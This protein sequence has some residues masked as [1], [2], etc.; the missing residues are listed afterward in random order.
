MMKLNSLKQL[1]KGLSIII[2]LI[3]VLGLLLQPTPAVAQ[4]NQMFSANIQTMSCPLS[5]NTLSGVTPPARIRDIFPDPTFARAVGY[6]LRNTVGVTS[7]NDVVSQDDL[8]TITWLG[9]CQILADEQPREI[10]SLEGI[11][12]LKNLKVLEMPNQEI[13]DISILAGLSQLF[14]VDLSYNPIADASPLANTGPI[15]Y[16][17]LSGTHINSLNFLASI[18]YDYLTFL[19]VANTQISDIDILEPFLERELIFLDLS[20]TQVSDISVLSG[21]NNLI[22]LN[23]FQTQVYDISALDFDELTQLEHIGLSN[24]SYAELEALLTTTTRYFELQTLR[25]SNVDI[26]YLILLVDQIIYLHN[27]QLYQA[28]IQDLSFLNEFYSLKTLNL[29]HNQINDQILS[30]LTNMSWKY[31]EY[32]DLSYNN[33]TNANHLKNLW[34]DFGWIDSSI[35]ISNNKISDISFLFGWDGYFYFG[36]FDY[37]NVSHNQISDLSPFLHIESFR[38]HT[39]NFSH[40]QIS[41][42]APIIEAF[43]EGGISISRLILSHNLIEN[44]EAMADFD[45]EWRAFFLNTLDL[46]HNRISDLSPLAKM[47]ENLD[48]FVTPRVNLSHNRIYDISP[49][50]FLASNVGHFVLLDL[51]VTN[52]SITRDEILLSFAGESTFDIEIENPLRTIEGDY[53]SAFNISHGGMLSTSLEYLM[54]TDL[55]TDVTELSLMFTHHESI[56]NIPVCPWVA[57]IRFSGTIIQPLTGPENV[58][59]IF[60]LQD[61]NIDGVTTN[62]IVSDVI[63]GTSLGGNM[64]ADPEK[65]GF[66]FIGWN[67]KPD[68]TGTVFDSTTV[69]IGDITIYAQ[70]QE[71]SQ[72]KRYTVTF[73]LRGGNIGGNTA[74]YQVTDVVYGET[75]VN[76]MPGNPTRTGFTFAGWFD[77][78]NATGGN[79]FTIATAVYED[80]TVFARWQTAGGGGTGGGSGG[81]DNGIGNGGENGVNG[82][83]IPPEVPG[84][85]F[86]VPF[87]SDHIAYLVGFQDGTIRPNSTITRAEVATIFFRLITDEY[88]TQIWSQSNPFRDVTLNNWFNN[89]VSTL[90]NA[91][92]IE[93]FPD[94]TFRGNQAITRAEFATMIARFVEEVDY[95]GTDRFNDIN[96]HWAREAINL[97]GYFNWVEGYRDGSFR[98]NQSITRAEAAAIVNRLLN[99]QPEDADDLL[100]GMV[101]WP[102]NMNQNAWFY[103]YIQEAT[104]SHDFE[105]KADGVHER[106]IQLVEPRPWVLLERPDSTPNSIFE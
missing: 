87:S 24:I 7:T 77:T 102:D 21:F 29:S 76:R 28:N 75:L 31:L 92:I 71:V 98:P 48:I 34:N 82:D 65:S 85:V 5:Y 80:K 4:E 83:I 6:A 58:T 105:M 64:P 97:A 10:Q 3:I 35:N 81:S 86:I 37:V 39:L 36:F 16:L 90:T 45:S 14:H 25:L 40:N 61:G 8:D 12:Y 47:A 72:E 94:G 57:C 53:I 44:I 95:T 69:V 20:G 23:L 63:Y 73:D 54:W 99:R 41:D 38:A 70:W 1:N 2:A 66:I 59:V 51:D 33:I 30:T 106:W 74:N 22:K 27:L 103:L 104:N 91:D 79:Q 18:P 15:N 67:T 56:P 32:L 50:G 55:S 60:D 62:P 49:V 43:S 9:I 52:Q 26:Q 96:T 17:D 13:Q 68:G 101:I 89:A 88:R 42:L 100:P 78:Q 11:Q 46:S 93:G 84:P 19:Y